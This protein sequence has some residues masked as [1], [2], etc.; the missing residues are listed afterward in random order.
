MNYF[1]K[2]GDQQYGP[3]TLA[4]LQQYVAQGNISQQDLARSEAMTDW[5]PVSSILGNVPVPTAT[6]SAFGAAGTGGG[7]ANFPLPPNLHWAVVLVLAII[8]FGI[9]GLIW[10]FV[11]AAWIRKVR[12][13]SRG[14]YWLVGYIAS[15]VLAGFLIETSP[16]VAVIFNLATIVLYLVAIFTM[17]S[18][19]EDCY[20]MLT[21]GGNSLSGVMTFFFSFVYFQYHLCEIREAASTAASS[22]AAR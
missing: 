13:Q 15:A 1:V 6:S 14:L 8:T 11:E 16:G 18:D 9:F 2:R 17:R 7:M 10:L 19:L 22:A 5:V 20:A 4:A 3:Y 12:P 21:P